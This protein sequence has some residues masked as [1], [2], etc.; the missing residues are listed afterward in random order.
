MGVG[1]SDGKYYESADD[2]WHAQLFGEPEPEQKDEPKNGMFLVRHGDTSLNDEDL[3]HGWVDAPL[4]E[5]GIEQA[6]KAAESLKDKEITRIVSSDLPRAR[7][8]ANI[9]GK[10]LG[11]PV[12]LNPNLRTWD[13]GNFDYT[14]K[15]KEFEKYTRQNG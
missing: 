9:I 15:H 13:A 10:K 14:D 3:V 1:T 12:T 4:N 11:I 5:K 6:H 7:Q 8:T 2:Y